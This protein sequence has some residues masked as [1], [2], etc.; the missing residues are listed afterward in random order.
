MFNRC[1]TAAVLAAGIVLVAAA[2]R[3]AQPTE[4]KAFFRAGQTFITFKESDAAKYNLYRSDKKIDDLKAATLVCALPKNSGQYELE[5][6]RK[7]AAGIAKKP[8]YNSR[9]IIED[10]PSADPAKML[11]EGVGL[12]V[13]TPKQAGTAF[14]AVA[15]VG[16]GGEPE[17]ALAPGNS[18]QA[19][20]AEKAEAPGAVLVWQGEIKDKDG[21]PAGQQRVYCHWMDTADWNPQPTGGYAFNFG[22]GVPEGKQAR[23]V[24]MFLHGFS[25][26]YGLHGPEQGMVS[27]TP[28]DPH[29][30][31]FYGHRDASGQKVVNYSQRRMVMTVDVVLRHLKSEGVEV[32]ANKVYVHGGSMGGTGGNLLGARNGDV[33]A[34]VLASK[35]AVDHNRNGGWT[36]DA[37]N[38]LWGTK[39]QNLP[40]NEG[41]KVW[42]HVNLIQWHLAN[43]KQETAFFLDAHASND[44][45]VPFGAVPEYYAALQKAKRPFAAVW[46]PWG[47]SGFEDPH[48]PNHE[49]WGVFTFN[50]DESV[51]AIGNCSSNDEP[52]PGSKGEINTHVEWSSRE[53]KFDKEAD[54]AKAVDLPDRWEMSFRSCNFRRSQSQKKDVDEQTADITP[55]RCQ[56]FRPQPGSKCRWENWSW[57]DPAAPKKV[58]DGTVTADE[59]G[60]VTAPKF[61]I[62]KAGLGNRLVIYPEK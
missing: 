15:A 24:C 52:K 61:V 34:A 32:D 47:H 22:V 35:G 11:P 27:I 29:Q 16:A 60:L 40:T 26:Y 45:S 13:V 2:A 6:Q 38:R 48:W 33:F 17:A 21:K 8:L 12:A 7:V 59:H 42:D 62:A 55:R 19:G 49:W 37:A 58:A 9:Y 51:P 46:G 31:W 54:K 18:L 4:L 57:A 41:P 44:E 3:A 25:G 30:A 43:V 14:Y 53:C 10:N 36:G 1:L 20:V 39:E 5:V 50:K 23:G 28:G 56:K